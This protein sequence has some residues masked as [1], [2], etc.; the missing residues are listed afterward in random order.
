MIRV[1][2]FTGTG[3]K[4]TIEVESEEE[5]MAWEST[6]GMAIR[7][8]DE[9][10]EKYSKDKNYHEYKMQIQFAISLCQSSTANALQS[11]ARWKLKQLGI[12]L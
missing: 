3:Q 1:S 5:A 7:I 10:C 2:T 11:R 8:V 12:E 6:Y 9:A 4:I